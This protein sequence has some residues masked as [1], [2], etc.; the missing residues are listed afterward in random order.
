MHN[1]V[2]GCGNLAVHFTLTV[3]CLRLI[4]KQVIFEKKNVQDLPNV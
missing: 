3:P 2:W 1:E 4:D